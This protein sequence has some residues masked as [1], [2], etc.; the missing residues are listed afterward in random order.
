MINRIAH[1]SRTA[2]G[3]TA[4]SCIWMTAGVISYKLCPLNFNCE[5]C[6]FDAAMQRQKYRSEGPEEKSPPA[7]P[8]L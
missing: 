5:E 3:Q 7:P 8:Q 6:E 4:K 2:T 1:S